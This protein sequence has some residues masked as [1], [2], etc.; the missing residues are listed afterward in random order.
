M[1]DL[2]RRRYTERPDCW[3][4]YFGDVHVGTI[5]CRVG[6]RSLRTRQLAPI[7]RNRRSPVQCSV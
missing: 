1:P 7:Y 3:H 2:S 4:V 5:A 6:H